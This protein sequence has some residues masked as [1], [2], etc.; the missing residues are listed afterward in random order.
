MFRHTLLI[1]IT[2]FL[3]SACNEQNTLSRS[4]RHIT[5]ALGREVCLPDTI[6][7]I[8]AINEST[9]RM[10]SYVGATDLVCGIEDVEIR[11]VAFTHIFANPE[12]RKSVV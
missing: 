2:L 5:D 10:I 11:G 9:M 6:R 4:N 12:D 8:I 3:L 7:K 1:I